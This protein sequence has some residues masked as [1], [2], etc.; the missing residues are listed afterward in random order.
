MPTTCYYFAL[1][2]IY[3]EVTFIKGKIYSARIYLRMKGEVFEARMRLNNNKII[4]MK[5]KI[6]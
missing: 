6:Y 5:N 4:L 2:G 3:I 1:Q